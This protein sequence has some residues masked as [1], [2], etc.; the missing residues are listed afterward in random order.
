[1]FPKPSMRE[2]LRHTPTGKRGPTVV[3][4]CCGAGRQDSLSLGCAGGRMN[5][6]ASGKGEPPQDSS[7][8]S[9]SPGDK[10]LVLSFFY[11]KSSLNVV[12]RFL[13]TVTLSEM[14]ICCMTKPVSS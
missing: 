14:V 3:H 11:S 5:S 10:S 7:W 8:S 1:M 9:G 13:D 12:E 4:P 2:E 6:G